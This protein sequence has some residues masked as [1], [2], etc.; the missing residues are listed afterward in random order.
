LT[1]NNFLLWQAQILPYLRSQR[2][3]SCVTGAI[4]CPSLTLPAQEKDVAPVPNPA[5]VVWFEQDQAILSALL[6]SL[7]PETHS[8]CL[9]LKT[10]K[11]VWDKLDSLY[12]AQS[13]AHAMQMRMQLA[14]LKKQDLLAAN[15]FHRGQGLVDT[16]T[17]T[18]ALLG[19]DEIV[20]YLL[21]GLPKE[22]D[23]LVTSVTTRVE[24][25][26]LSEVYTN[27]LSFEARLATR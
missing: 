8:Q 10:S 16:L 26:P 2:L 11:A 17:A 4:P 13:R 18:G 22:Y 7:S 21:T 5:Y 19:G 20:A 24:P 12:A 3:I 6:S 25:M 9:F 15:Y 23:S 14:N 1:H 27:M